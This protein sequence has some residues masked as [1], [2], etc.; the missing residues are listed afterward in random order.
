MRIG[1]KTTVGRFLINLLLALALA[2]VL[3]GTVVAQLQLPGRPLTTDPAQDLRPSWSP[4]GELIAFQSSRSGSYDIL[5]MDADGGEQHFVV[6]GPADDRRPAWSPDG[7]WLAF[8]SD[9]SGNREIWAVDAAGENLT[10]LSETLGQD[11]F[12]S[13]SPDGSQMAFF[14]YEGGV[15][16]LWVIRLNDVLAGGAMPVPQ[17]VTTDMANERNN[18]CT[19]ACHSPAWSPDGTQLAY[20]RQNHTQ[21]WVA[22][23]DG[24]NAHAVSGGGLNEHFPI[25]TDD[26]RILFLS[27]RLTDNQE[28]V[29]DIWVMDADG[30][31]LTLLHEAIPHGGPLEFRSGT[32][33]IIFHSPRSGNFDIY[34]TVLGEEQVIEQP[35]A[36][37]VP[38]LNLGVQPTTAAAAAPTTA[39]VVPPSDSPSPSASRGLSLA[40]VGVAL[41]G[42]GLLAGG[43]AVLFLARRGR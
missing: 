29:N 16:D 34:T 2:A 39:A 17:R 21:I 4:D 22:G 14:S 3:A 32:D 28:P 31:N 30:Q 18:Q 20:T 13:W 26:G 25:W 15:M 8:D 11:T 1:R 23:V 5:V 9:R 35:A 10:Q 41:L 12:P 42:L 38:D 36:T 40:V 24:S 37:S 7:A 33:T 27:E 6:Q 43:G 19:F